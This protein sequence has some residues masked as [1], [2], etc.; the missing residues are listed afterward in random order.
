MSYEFFG[1]FMVLA[2]V[3]VM[4]S[5]RL[6]TWTMGALFVALAAYQT[7]FALFVAGILIANLFREFNQQKSADLAGAM[8]CAIGLV[9]ILLPHAG[10]GLVYIAGATCLTAGVAFYTPVRR[11]FENRLSDFLGWIS[12][13]LY[14]VQAAVIYSFSLRWLD[15]LASLGFEPSAQRWIVGT[16]TLPAAIFFA[17]VFCPVNDMAVTLSRRIGSAF[18]MLCDKHPRNF[19]PKTLP[20][21]T[22]SR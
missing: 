19:A 10:F 16:A 21:S 18:V 7:F 1:S 8:L 14:L 3:A 12:F 15:V 17:I 4:R 2:I 6:R 9:M 20:A 11:L 5:W 13:P 22:L